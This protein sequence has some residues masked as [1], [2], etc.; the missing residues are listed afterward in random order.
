MTA[1]LRIDDVLP[2]DLAR[3]RELFGE[4]EASLG[5]SLDFQGFREELAALPGAYAPPRGALLMA[6]AS[7]EPAGCIAL[8]P[9]DAHEAEVKRL[10][11][12]PAFRGSGLGERLVRAVIDRASRA[13]YRALRL[14]T[15]GTM[16]RA[17]RL[18]ER[19]GFVE[20]GPYHAATLPG[21]R[22]YRRPLD[23]VPRD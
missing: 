23:G 15:L 6:W 14:D 17:M 2:R 22:W 11:V 13:G 21:M 3:C 16:D 7:G 8:R 4:Y 5:I 20:T 12:R 9:L 18:Y 10:Y 19:L 1:S